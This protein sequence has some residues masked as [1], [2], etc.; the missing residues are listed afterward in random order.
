MK[1]PY[2]ISTQITRSAY[3][4]FTQPDVDLHYLLTKSLDTAEYING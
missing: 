1:D 2:C 4:F 3:A